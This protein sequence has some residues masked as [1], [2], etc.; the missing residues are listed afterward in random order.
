MLLRQLEKTSAVADTQ[1]LLYYESY[2]P[3]PYTALIHPSS[4]FPTLASETFLLYGSSS[5]YVPEFSEILQVQ[6]SRALATG[7]AVSVIG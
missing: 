1:F 3:E 6:P 7:D 2:T 4:T 5:T